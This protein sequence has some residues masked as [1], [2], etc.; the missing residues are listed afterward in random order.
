VLFVQNLATCRAN[1]RQKIE[2]VA[3][4]MHSVRVLRESGLSGGPMDG[5]RSFVA[6]KKYGPFAGLAES[7]A[8]ENLICS[9]PDVDEAAVVGVDDPDFGQ[10]LKAFVRRLLEQGGVR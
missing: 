10:R 8:V 9:H 7:A 6:A 4:T 2:S 1:V 3:V 5:L